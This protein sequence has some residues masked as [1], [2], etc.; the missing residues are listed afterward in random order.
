[1]TRVTG[2]L[3]S[4][5]ASGTIGDILTYSK[6]KG[7]PYVRTRVIPANPQTDDQTSIR[8]T[9]T[10]GVSAWRDEASVPA[11][12]KLSWDYY[13]SGTGMSGFNRYIKLFIE[14]NTQQVAPWTNI[15]PN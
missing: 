7:L 10:A 5:T 3:F 6:W 4:L 8:N 9:L 1:M 11:A 13:A 15:D 12:S 2:A 14:T